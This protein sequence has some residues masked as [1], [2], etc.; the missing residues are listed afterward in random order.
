MPNPKA[1]PKLRYRIPPP[2]R[3][4]PTGRP[5][6]LPADL[7]AFSIRFLPG[8]FG[9]IEAVLGDKETKVSFVREAVE[10]ELRRRESELIS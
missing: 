9:R 10:R 2:P 7:E 5:K 6:L 1:R 4:K 3:G 8:T